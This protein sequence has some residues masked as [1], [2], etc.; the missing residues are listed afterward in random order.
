MV[1]IVKK[2]AFF[3]VC[4]KCEFRRETDVRFLCKEKCGKN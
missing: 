4:I 2:L 3:V 1:G